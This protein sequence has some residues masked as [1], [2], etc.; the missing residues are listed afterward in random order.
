MQLGRRFSKPLSFSLDVRMKLSR[1]ERR[2]AE[3]A[4]AKRASAEAGVAPAAAG[5]T[6]ALVNPPGDWTTQAEDPFALVR[7]LGAET[8]KRKAGEGDREAQRSLG[9]QFMREVE[10]GVGT[11]L[12]AAGRSPKADVGSAR[13]A[14]TVSSYSQFP[15]VH[16][17]QLRLRGTADQMNLICRCQ[18]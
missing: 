7:T 15:A 10:R 2:K 17:F 4:A 9:Y 14:P 3:R 6:A 16:N 18:P 11:L 13:C 8:V 1:Q 12:G 5:A